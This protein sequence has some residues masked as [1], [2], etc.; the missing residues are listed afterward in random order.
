VKP[1]I[2]TSPP[3]LRKAQ[4]N[5]RLTPDSRRLLRVT[6]LIETIERYVEVDAGIDE[7]GE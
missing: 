5:I 1:E 6:G 7:K 2:T 4:I 3:G